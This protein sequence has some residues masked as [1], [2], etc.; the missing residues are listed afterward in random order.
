MKLL[1][2]RPTL[3]EQLL[4]R[5]MLA[6]PSNILLVT[7]EERGALEEELGKWEK[8]IDAEGELRFPVMNTPVAEW[9][10]IRLYPHLEEQE[11]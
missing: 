9:P 4:A 2:S 7:P 5:Y 3:R 8:H 1:D 10:I 6:L 11:Q